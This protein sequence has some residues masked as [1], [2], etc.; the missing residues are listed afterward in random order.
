[1]EQA[2][3]F[4][5]AL[6]EWERSLP[7]IAWTDFVAEAQQGRVALFSV[8][9][10]NGFCHE[11]VLSSPRVKGIIPAV[12]AAFKAAH[13]IDVRNFVLAQDCHSP[14]SVEF[15]D[16]PPHCQMGTSEA[17]TIPEL[18]ELP[19]AD[20]YTVVSKNSL[21]AFHGTNLGEWL[22]AHRDLSVAV[23]VGDCTDLCVHQM[24]MHLKLYANAHNLKMRVIVPENAVQTYDM[25][26]KTAREIGALPHDANTL[27][28]L[29]LYHMRLNGVEVVREITTP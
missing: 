5:G 6:V 18:A 24:A 11:G 22:D 4:L 28:L 13:A 9:M 25:P 27:H 12:V 2:M 20:L 3:Q 17:N 29:F 8:D 16:F 23:V 7:A 15:A 19:F 14:N 1:M 26:I 21:N 10:I